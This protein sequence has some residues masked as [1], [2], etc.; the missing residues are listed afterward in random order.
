MVEQPE[1]MSV[2]R[3]EAPRHGFDFRIALVFVGFVVIAI[4]LTPAKTTEDGVMEALKGYGLVKTILTPTREVDVVRQRCQKTE[5]FARSAVVEKDTVM[6]L[7]NL[8]C[9]VQR[10]CRVNK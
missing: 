6:T 3:T 4:A 2:N 7:Y 1:Q 10:A 9:T 8:C 5:R